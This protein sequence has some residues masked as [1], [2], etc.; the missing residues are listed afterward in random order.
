MLSFRFCA[1]FSLVFFLKKKTVT[2]CNQR[3]DTL[4]QG[5]RGPRGFDPQRQIAEEQASSQL[6]R[7]CQ[8]A[9][10]LPDN[11]L[12]TDDALVDA[13]RH[14]KPFCLL[15]PP[16]AHPAGDDDQPRS[17]IAP[18]ALRLRPAFVLFCLPEQRHL[19]RTFRVWWPSACSGENEVA[20]RA[21]TT[22]IA[23]HQCCVEEQCRGPS[24]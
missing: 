18:T 14:K 19:P 7:M 16:A 9:R 5:V 8:A 22:S 3:D 4:M 1:G 21:A 15:V 17:S 6:H 13:R 2:R 20:S 11:L 24:T 12:V 23:A 10:A